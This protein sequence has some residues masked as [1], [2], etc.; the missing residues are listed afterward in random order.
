MQPLWSIENQMI[1]DISHQTREDEVA[2]TGRFGQAS[3]AT[4]VA[5][6]YIAQARVLH[7]S[8]ELESPELHRVTLLVDG[9]DEDRNS[10][11][12]G[13]VL[14][15]SD[16]SIPTRELEQMMLIYS[17]MEFATA[18]KPALLRFL[19]TRSGAPALYLDPDIQVFSSL[20][21]IVVAAD[22]Y[23][24]VV[25]PHST[26]PLPRDGLRHS[27]QTIM[28]A[29]MYNLGFIAVSP[30]ALRFLSWWHERLLV[31]AVADP[32]AGLFTDQRW[33]DWVP[34]LFNVSISR[35]PGDNVAYWNMHGRRLTRVDE[36]TW[37]SNGQPLRFIHFSGFNPATPWVISKHMADLPR[38]RSS[39]DDD[40]HLALDD[41]SELLLR[42][43]HEAANEFA[44]RWDQLPGGYALTALRR[45]IFREMLLR[46][47]L[48]DAPM[49][50][51]EP[52]AF[53]VWLGEKDVTGLTRF[54]R[55]VW[56][57][58]QDLQQAFPDLSR[59]SALKYRNWLLA[60]AW[61]RELA[62]GLADE[63]GPPVIDALLAGSTTGDLSAFG[64]NVIAYA[65]AELG[66]GEAGRRV[67]HM[68]RAT[69]AP[70]RLVSVPRRILSRGRHRSMTKIEA[71]LGYENSIV[72]VNADMVSQVTHDLGLR[73]TRG[74]RIGL[75]FWELD[76]FP[77]Y[78]SEALDQVHEVWVTSEMTRAALQPLTS[79]PV[80]L[81]R[82]PIDVPREAT[83][84]TRDQLGIPGGRVLMTS[85]DYLSVPRRKNPL[86]VIRAYRDAVEAEEGVTLIV[87][88]INAHHAPLAH[89]EIVRATRGR[90]DIRIMDAYVSYAEMQA[91]IEL[92]DGY[93]SLHRSEGFG[94]NVADAV[95]RSTPV[96]TTAYSGTLEFTNSDVAAL[97]PWS[98]IAVGPGA[99]P[100]PA[101]A[102][103]AEPDHNAAVRAIRD[104]LDDA[105]TAHIRA[106]RGVATMRRDWSLSATSRRI[107]SLILP[108]P[109]TSLEFS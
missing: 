69:G 17:V 4:I 62:E 61:Y 63:S 64:W 84:Y 71:S 1:P 83:S 108:P 81:V 7:G 60:D 82:I 50:F 2:V 43:G 5:R 36:K 25:T 49:P 55:L 101:N 34:S 70:T 107:G 37:L 20:H 97:I 16:L 85:F 48:E 68:L 18:L 54:A 40:L 10:A 3:A 95:A 30:R 67:A 98:P 99:K 96:I 75:W 103:W 57:L 45:G 26:S 88:S 77:D 104:L 51:S 24:I 15:P 56:D 46:G 87:K 19:V 78:I 41:Y 52:G 11:G 76:E 28:I 13:E 93:I 92:C 22:A 58:R 102:V 66:V 90:D 44:Y 106:I 91:M 33:I 27:E 65:D 105:E 8:L 80:T 47:F 23:G 31:D 14:L 32:A 109:L 12:L 39:R 9:M 29:G 73:G 72:C 6:N 42:A 79:K 59:L 35:H 100:Y 21:E 86:G 53:V 94:L 38:P 74:R 89:D